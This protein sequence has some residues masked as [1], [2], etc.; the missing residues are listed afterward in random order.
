MANEVVKSVNNIPAD[1]DGEVWLTFDNFEDI[2]DYVV[3]TGSNSGIDNGTTYY[4]TWRIWHSGRVEQWLT[5]DISALGLTTSETLVDGMLY[6]TRT[7]NIPWFYITFANNNIVI[8]E[9]F[10]SNNGYSGWLWQTGYVTK[11]FPSNYYVV[12]H[13]KDAPISGIISIYASGVGG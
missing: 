8:K 2:G 13:T 5:L 11:E 4:R 6:R 10:K 12:R 9:S 7:I 1:A 3:G